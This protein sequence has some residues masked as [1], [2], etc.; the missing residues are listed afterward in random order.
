MTRSISLFFIMST[1]F[2]R[3]SESLSTFW[4][5]T[6]CFERNSA[7]PLVASILK[8][9]FSSILAVSRRGSLS[10]F[11]MLKKAVPLVGS[12]RPTANWLL[13]KA[14]PTLWSMPITSP[15][16]FISGPRIMSTPGNFLK[17]KTDSLTDTCFT[18]GSSVR[19]SSSRLF[20]IM[21]FVASFARGTPVA[22]LTK[23]TVL[24]ALGFTSS[25]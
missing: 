4:H 18:S 21:T 11:F 13:A 22:L 10:P 2:G 1:M 7:V 17:G 12:S 9:S 19:P 24:D 25:T 3:P 20:P 16:D 23:G 6:P 15:V 5:F 8:P 14:T